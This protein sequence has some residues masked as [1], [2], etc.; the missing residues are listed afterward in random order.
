MIVLWIQVYFCCINLTMLQRLLLYLLCLLPFVSKGQFVLKVKAT[1]TTDSIGYLRAS[2]FDEKNFIPKDTLNL[3]KPIQ[4][5]RNTKSI[6]GGIY[7]IYFPK[8]KQKIHFILEDKDTVLLEIKG[9]DYLNSATINTPKNK[10]F[11]DYQRLERSLSTYDSSY[12]TALKLGKKFNQV[13]KAAYF[14]IKTD[15]LMDF[16]KANLKRFKSTDAIHIYFSTLNKLDEQVPNKRDYVARASFLKKFDLNEPKLFFTPT[17]RQVLVEYLSFYPLQGD[18]LIMGLDEVFKSLLCTNKA[19]SFVFDYFTKVF[20]NR[21]VQNNTGAYAYLINKYVKNNT[22]AFL[23]KNNKQAFINE[24]AQLEAQQISKPVM[25]LIL[26]DTLGVKKDLLAFSKN[27][28]YTVLIFFDPNCEH[29]KTEVPKMD[30]TIQVLEKELMVTIGKF[31]VCNEPTMPLNQWKTFIQNHALNLNYEH[32]IFNNDIEL[33][34]AFDA[35]SNPLF[36]LID[37]EG[38]LLAK[39]ISPNTLKKELLQSFKNFKR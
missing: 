3:N 15:S 16:R 18:S 36:F 6:V 1:N 33:R 12:A 10:V 35:F 26:E 8:S 2:L 9:S 24:L 21:E 30:S 31:A 38:I 14:K 20:K 28:N 11:L 27:Y 17:M 32:V 5:I 39:K 34:K 7:F 23:D 22:C 19:Y 13:Q 4:T 37:K 29:C 25:N